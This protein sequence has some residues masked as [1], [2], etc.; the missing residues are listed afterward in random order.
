MGGNKTAYFFWVCL[1]ILVALVMPLTAVVTAMSVQVVAEDSVPQLMLIILAIISLA[2]HV[3]VLFGGRLAHAS[4]TYLYF[5]S[6]H[7]RLSN[8]LGTNQRAARQ[9]LKKLEAIFIPYVHHWRKHN[10]MYSYIEAGPFD[11]DI[12]E[13]LRRQ[14]P[15]LNKNQ[16][17]D[18]HQ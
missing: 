4:K 5:A 6:K 3:L 2:A 14:F 11:N 12:A 7:A 18:P 8:E 16:N 10:S 15:Y 13:L 17:D 9:R 1:G